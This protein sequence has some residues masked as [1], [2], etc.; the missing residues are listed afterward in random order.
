ME[1]DSFPKIEMADI[2]EIESP[3]QKYTDG[4]F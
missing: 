4:C 1:N 2:S 3:I